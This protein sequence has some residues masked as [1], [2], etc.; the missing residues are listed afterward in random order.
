MAG[1]DTNLLVRLLVADDARQLAKV[2]ALVRDA[3]LQDTPLF[4]PVT[5]VLEL[6]WVL[7]SRYGFGKD[8]IVAAIVGL[9][10][11]R[12]LTFQLEAALEQAL[13]DYSDCAADFAD[14]LHAALCSTH[15]HAPLL[16]FDSKAARL[17][18]VE[19]VQAG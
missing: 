18:D 19:L 12:E 14:C 5:V 4:I 1:L 8:Q 3:A 2:Q 13:H 6:E 15:S 10:E 16:T 7:R 17:P 9:L 11:S